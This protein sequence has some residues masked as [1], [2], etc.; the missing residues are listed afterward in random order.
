VVGKRLAHGIAV[1]VAERPAQPGLE[2]GIVQAKEL[3]AVAAPGGVA[4]GRDRRPEGRVGESA[5]TIDPANCDLCGG[6][7]GRTRVGATGA[8]VVAGGAYVAAV[9]ATRAGRSRGGG[10]RAWG[11]QASRVVVV[12]VSHPKMLHR[13]IEQLILRGCSSR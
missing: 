3:V 10:W 12:W 2:R 11:R 6:A 7:T 13:H 9:P 1:R 5:A 8:N 4:L